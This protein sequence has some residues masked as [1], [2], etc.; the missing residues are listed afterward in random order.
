MF[1]TDTVA[2]KKRHFVGSSAGSRAE[3]LASLSCTDWNYFKF[4]NKAYLPPNINQKCLLSEQPLKISVLRPI[5]NER[6]WNRKEK[7]VSR[8]LS[9]I[10]YC[11]LLVLRTFSLSFPFSLLLGVNRPLNRVKAQNDVPDPEHPS[12][13]LGAVSCLTFIVT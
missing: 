5:H 1:T 11:F 10:L 13:I 6:K 3:T 9:F 2:L 4:Q 8:C 7:N 12:Y